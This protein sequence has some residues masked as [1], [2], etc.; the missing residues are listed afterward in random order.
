MRASIMSCCST[1]YLHILR[2]THQTGTLSSLIQHVGSG[3][4]LLKSHQEPAG[5]GKTPHLSLEAPRTR[6]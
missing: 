4:L 6:P 1:P 3:V 2:K 5:P